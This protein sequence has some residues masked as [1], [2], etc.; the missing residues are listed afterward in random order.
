M[1]ARPGNSTRSRSRSASSGASAASDQRA[2]AAAGVTITHPER[3]VFARLQVSKGDVADYYREIAA[4]MLPELRDRPLSLL[5]CPEGTGSACFFQKH[6]TTRLGRHV[7]GLRLR[8]S[9][10]IGSYLCVDDAD[11]LL[12]LVQ[13]NTLEF[14]PWGARAGATDRADRIVFDLDPHAGVPWKAVAAGAVAVRAHLQS[15]GL[16]AFLRTT[17][18]KGLHVVV[19]LRPAAP[20]LRVRAFARAVAE[21]LSA[22]QPARFVAV[23]GEEK[24][25]GRIFIDWLRNSRGATS[26]AA[27]SLRARDAAGVAM[28]LAWNALAGLDSGHAFTIVNALA[29]VRRRRADPWRDI[30]RVDQTLPRP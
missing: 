11:G 16:A 23:A 22:R 7:R 10:G 14:H 26:I 15:L 24:R 17:G 9:S 27:Y 1:T 13:M 12:E 29:H 5:R 30:D 3:I 8:D 28:P 6:L 21:V 18:G 2:A 20:W 4:W 25:A 19:P